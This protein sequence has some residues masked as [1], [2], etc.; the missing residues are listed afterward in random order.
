M[1]IIFTDNSKSS[2]V[3]TTLLKKY[4][5]PYATVVHLTKE[6]DDFY[7]H[8]VSGSEPKNEK[9]RN[10]NHVIIL[11]E[12]FKDPKVADAVLLLSKENFRSQITWYRKYIDKVD[13]NPSTYKEIG[14]LVVSTHGRMRKVCKLIPA[15]GKRLIEGF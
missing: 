3:Y 11:A 1:A 15:Q 5:F 6:A 13:E 10:H 12:N 9:L 2:Q 14:N 4:V 8:V 7:N